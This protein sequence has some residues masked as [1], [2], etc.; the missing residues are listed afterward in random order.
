MAFGKATAMIRAGGTI[1]FVQPFADLLKGAPCI[2]VGVAD[3]NTQAHSENESLHLGDWV[4]AMR[5]TIHLYDELARVPVGKRRGRHDPETPRAPGDGPVRAE[6]RP[7]AARALIGS[8]RARWTPSCLR[9]EVTSA[10]IR[11]GHVPVDGGS[12]PA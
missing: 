5:S 11:P 12:V 7:R 6:S 8:A 2:L 4:K 10:L 9:G 3:P 1:G